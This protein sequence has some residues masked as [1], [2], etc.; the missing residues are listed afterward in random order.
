[1]SRSFA[2]TE[3]EIRGLLTEFDGD[4]DRVREIVEQAFL[5]GVSLNEAR[6]EARDPVRQSSQPSHTSAVP[7]GFSGTRTRGRDYTWKDA[8][9]GI[10]WEVTVFPPG[11]P[12][13]EGGEP[14]PDEKLWVAFRSQV[15]SFHVA[16]GV[17]PDAKDKAVLE[18]LV[19]WGTLFEGG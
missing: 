6:K 5:N 17:M 3:E 13:D 15:W 4:L 12:V 8:R 2:F 16:S 14:P 18:V 9:T 19:D 10:N 7:Q 11:S 1:M